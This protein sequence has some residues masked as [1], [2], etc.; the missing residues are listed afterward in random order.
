LYDSSISI[1][2]ALD[3]ENT[4][5]FTNSHTC[6]IAS[7]SSFEDL[8][9]HTSIISTQKLSIAVAI[10]TLSSTLAIFLDH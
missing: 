7:K 10:L 1:L 9:N 8:A 6:L 4:L 3:N 2:L 5:A